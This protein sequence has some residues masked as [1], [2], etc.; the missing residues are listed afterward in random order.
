MRFAW[1]AAVFLC[2]AAWANGYTRFVDPAEHAF[3]AEVPQG[4]KAGGL[5]VRYGPVS[6]APFVQ[7]MSPDGQV[8]VQLGDWHIKDYADIPGWRQG[9][10]YTP[11]TSIA[12]VRR[13]ES[14]GQYAHGYAAAFAREVDCGAPVV[15]G[16]APVA[17]PA[18]LSR[19]PG[20]R[21]ETALAH[22]SC[23][24][25]GRKFDGRVMASVQATPV[26]NMMTWS[27]VYLASVVAPQDRAAA[28]VAAWDAMRKSVA[29][30]PAWNARQTRLAAA[31]VKPAMDQLDG[32]L[33]Q[34]QAFDEHV[35][36]GD[37]TVEDPL[38]GRRSEVS[39]GVAPYYFA[40]A[41]GHHYTSYDPT[42]RQ[43]YHG[44]RPMQ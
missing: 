21:L 25:D 27:V 24:R 5:L 44:V 40:D 38:T 30:S 9:Q 1:V 11:G 41:L 33:K 14:A 34:A 36:N 42:P 17:D 43:G 37:I 4:W 22:F 8:F 20:S 6:I 12:Y 10:L 13:L 31:A 2:S 26:M 7:A 16:V 39:M 15:T 28:A 29:F 3:S 23:T 32:M 18:G 19:A 35:I